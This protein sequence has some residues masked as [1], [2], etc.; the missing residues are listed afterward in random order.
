MDKE[1]KFHDHTT[2]LVQ[3]VLEVD[4]KLLHCELVSVFTIRLKFSLQ[5]EL[6]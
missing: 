5:D 1:E 6:V 4:C 2:S 3:T